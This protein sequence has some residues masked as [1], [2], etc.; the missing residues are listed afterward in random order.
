MGGGGGAWQR[1][2]GT[3][4]PHSG[5]DFWQIFPKQN[6]GLSNIKHSK[7]YQVFR[8]YAFCH[9]CGNT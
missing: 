4:R 9:I 8:F 5:L 7:A 2:W 3:A 6:T 1:G